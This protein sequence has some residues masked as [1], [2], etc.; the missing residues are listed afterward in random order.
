VIAGPG[1]MGRIDQGVVTLWV[2]HHYFERPLRY[3][4]FG[5]TGKQV[6][7]VLHVQDLFELITRQLD[8]DDIWDGRV[9]NV[10]GGAEGSLSL[11]ELTQLCRRVTGNTVPIGSSP[12]THPFDVR[13]YLSDAGRVRDDLQWGPQRT[14]EQIVIETC[15]WIAA[16]ETTLKPILVP[17]A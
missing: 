13:I 10:G 2:A 15:D 6:R 14:P 9:Y 12:D 1:Q 16:N 4:G 5:G 11:R 8:R 3:I 7:D 17:D